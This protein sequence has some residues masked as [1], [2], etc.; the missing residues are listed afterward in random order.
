MNKQEPTPRQVA[1]DTYILFLDKIDQFSYQDR[2]ACTNHFINF[3]NVE[4]VLLQTAISLGVK[5]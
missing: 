5:A 4:T 2:L 3:L 1:V